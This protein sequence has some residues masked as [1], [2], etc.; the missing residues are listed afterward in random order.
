MCQGGGGGS[1]SDKERSGGRLIGLRGKRKH[2]GDERMQVMPH[3]QC[4]R[5][6]VGLGHVTDEYIHR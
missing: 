3:K 5:T 1:G 4:S 2:V 6:F